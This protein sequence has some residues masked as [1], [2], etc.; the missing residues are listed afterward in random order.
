MLLLSF[1]KGFS[2]TQ[3]TMSSL[4]THTRPPIKYVPLCIH[5]YIHMYMPTGPVVVLHH[6][7]RGILPVPIPGRYWRQAGTEDQHEHSPGGALW[8]R[9]RRCLRVCCASVGSECSGDPGVSTAGA[10]LCSL[11]HGAQLLLPL[12]NLCQWCAPFQEV[13]CVY[14]CGWYNRQP[15]VCSISRGCVCVVIRHLPVGVLHFKKCIVWWGVSSILFLGSLFQQLRTVC[16]PFISRLYPLAVCVCVL[17]SVMYSQ[18]H[19]LW[20]V[21][22]MWLKHS[23]FTCS[24]SWQLH[25]LARAYTCSRQV[26]GSLLSVAL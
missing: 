8:P 12:A 26:S 14:M 13:E 17:Y 3:S 9:L 21:G 10:G 20:S 7:C 2:W 4:H 18:H 15:M 16:L 6:M 1:G 5:T 19:S 24:C 22:L 23:S 25:C 11:A